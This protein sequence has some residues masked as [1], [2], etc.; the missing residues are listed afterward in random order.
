MLAVK[1][2]VFIFAKRSAK[3]SSIP[4]KGEEVEEESS[5]EWRRRKRSRSQIERRTLKE[6][7]KLNISL[8]S[9]RSG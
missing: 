3:M 2:E 6:S 5:W 1:S 9:S 4:G 8:A 7:K